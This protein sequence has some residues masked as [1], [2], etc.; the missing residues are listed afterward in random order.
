[1]AYA[2]QALFW[3]RAYCL[4]GSKTGR[5]STKARAGCSDQKNV[6]FFLELQGSL[7][8]DG[9]ADIP[10]LRDPLTVNGYA[11]ISVIT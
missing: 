1:M 8:V 7:T 10:G 9:Y 11:D 3:L 2:V 5:P 6:C 4:C